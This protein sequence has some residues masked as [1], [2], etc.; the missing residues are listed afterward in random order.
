MKRTIEFILDDKMPLAIYA[1]FIKEFGAMM[2]KYNV[3]ADDVTPILPSMSS[4]PQDTTPEERVSN[5]ELEEEEDDDSPFDGEGT[6]PSDW[7][8]GGEKWK[9][10]EIVDKWRVIEAARKHGMSDEQ[11]SLKLD[12]GPQAIYQWQYQRKSKGETLENFREKLGVS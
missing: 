11:L 2:K 6:I 7:P 1:D 8:A 10:L 5:D 3:K 12:L 9:S 4:P